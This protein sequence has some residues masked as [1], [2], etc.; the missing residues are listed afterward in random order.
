MELPRK[1]EDIA[2]IKET[3]AGCPKEIF[4][5]CIQLGGTD[6]LA[7]CEMNEESKLFTEAGNAPMPQVGKLYE[8]YLEKN[9]PKSVEV[10]S[11]EPK[12]EPKKGLLNRIRNSLV[13]W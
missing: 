8:L 13:E 10:V 9:A 4:L 6:R 2:Y 7:L 11:S 3:C 1:F 12:P 5:R